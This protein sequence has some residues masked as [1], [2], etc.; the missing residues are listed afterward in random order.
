M[1]TK[2]AR[3]FVEDESGTG[4]SSRVNMLLGVLIGSF[5]VVWMVVH[6]TLNEGIFGIYMLTTGGVYSFGKWRETTEKRGRK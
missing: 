1:T 6:N 4:S 5:V 3:E 2:R